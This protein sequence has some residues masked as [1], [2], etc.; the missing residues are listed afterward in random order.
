MS[1]NGRDR[2]T[3]RGLRVWRKTHASLGGGQCGQWAIAQRT[4]GQLG[5]D[6][7]RRGFAFRDNLPVLTQAG[8]KSPR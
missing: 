6:R 7:S 3:A 5:H 4:R 1:Y 2:R 8:I